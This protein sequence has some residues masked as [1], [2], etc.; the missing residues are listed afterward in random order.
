[1]E[2]L[3]SH[4]GAQVDVTVEQFVPDLRSVADSP[5]PSIRFLSAHSARSNNAVD[6]SQQHHSTPPRIKLTGCILFN[7]S[8]ILGF[9]IAKAIYSY[10]GQAI[11][12]TTL[13]WVSGTALGIVYGFFWEEVELC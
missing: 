6:G 12:S 7:T 10:R 4:T 13:D 11:V 3:G 2:A 5:I 9:G 8:V 1:M